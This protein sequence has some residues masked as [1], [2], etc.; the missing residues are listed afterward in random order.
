MRRSVVVPGLLEQELAGVES[1]VKPGE[2]MYDPNPRNPHM[3]GGAPPRPPRSRLSAF[4]LRWED[5]TGRNN[6]HYAP[7]AWHN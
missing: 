5:T 1:G 7:F 2:P 4:N 3:G 6:G